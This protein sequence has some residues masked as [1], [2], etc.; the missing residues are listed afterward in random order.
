LHL[1]ETGGENF[2]PGCEHERNPV[3]VEIYPAILAN[4]AGRKHTHQGK[5]KLKGRAHRVGKAAPKAKRRKKIVGREV[6]IE[7]FGFTGRQ[8]EMDKRAIVCLSTS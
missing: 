8:R 7:G 4:A 6:E 5:L 1:T 2:P 3:K